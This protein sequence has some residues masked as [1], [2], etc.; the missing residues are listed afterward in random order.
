M[1]DRFCKA[2]EWSPSPDFKCVYIPHALKLLTMIEDSPE[3]R[4]WCSSY[5]IGEQYPDKSELLD[6]IRWFL[7][8]SYAEGLVV[9][10]YGEY[11]E[12]MNLRY[13][14]AEDAEASWLDG[15][16]LNQLLSVMAFHF[17]KDHH[18]NGSLINESLASGA[19]Y[20]IVL[21]LAKRV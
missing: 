16:S 4:R 21:E 17:R 9:T 11:L 18:R 5:W 3:L 7:H 12:Q 2:S 6:E 10:D 1:K 13:G 19:M 15:L 8:A 20:R 14:I